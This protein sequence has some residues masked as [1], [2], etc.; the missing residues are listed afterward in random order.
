MSPASRADGVGSFQ[1]ALHDWRR[2][3]RIHGNFHALRLQALQL[4]A[5]T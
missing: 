4:H 3:A 5:A 2:F 1:G